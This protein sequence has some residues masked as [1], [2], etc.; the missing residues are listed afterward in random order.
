MKQVFKDGVYDISNEQYHAADGIS[1]SRLMLLDKSPYHYWYEV[2]SGEAEK[3]EPTPAM[4]IGS[5]FHTLLLEPEKFGIEF[6]VSPKIDRRTKQGKEDWEEFSKGSEGKIILSD[7]QFLK[8][9][10]MVDLINRH[11]IVTTLLDEA[12]FEQSIFWTDKETGLQFK[13]RPDIWSQKMVV[14]LKTTADA[15]LHSFT[16]SSLNYGYYLQAGMVFEACK[17]IGQPFEMFV[18]LACEKEAPHVPAV[19]MMTDEALQ[20]GIDQFNSYKKRIKKCYDS[21]EWPGYPVQ[22]LGL[23]KYATINEDE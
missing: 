10:K 19:F 18:T 6:A 5:A 9:M 13:C 15:D 21:N 4:S 1:R 3:R 23:P 14:D 12:K 16:R 17:A 2:L 22:E 7:D 11:E 20:F 8:V